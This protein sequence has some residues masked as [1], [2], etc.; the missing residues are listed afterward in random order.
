MSTWTTR[1]KNIQLRMSI[2]FEPVLLSIQPCC[3]ETFIDSLNLHQ[4][5][6]LGSS[7]HKNFIFPKRRLLVL[8]VII[9]APSAS[10]SA[11][12]MEGFPAF[13]ATSPDPQSL[14]V[15]ETILWSRYPQV[16]IFRVR[17]WFFSPEHPFQVL[18]RNYCIP[19]ILEML[20]CC[21][22]SWLWK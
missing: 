5:N 4:H 8:I 7:F 9:H 17:I 11:L 1:L 15:Q 16:N 21:L 2:L 10:K 20:L 13:C 22:Q 3:V 12:Q 18:T 6:K 14:D 19:I